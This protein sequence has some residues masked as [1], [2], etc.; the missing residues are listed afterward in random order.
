MLILI[1]TLP[2]VGFIF[3]ITILHRCKSSGDYGN[4]YSLLLADIIKRLSSLFLPHYTI[5]SIHYNHSRIS[6]T[7]RVATGFA[8]SWALCVS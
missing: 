4:Y 8:L 5:K 2:F 6:I 1:T 3:A 7:A